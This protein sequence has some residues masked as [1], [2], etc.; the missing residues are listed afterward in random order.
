MVKSIKSKFII[1]SLIFTL[2]FETS[3]GYVLHS[4]R[5][6][7]PHSGNVDFAIVGLDA[8]GLLFFIVPGVIAFAVDI[9]SNTIYLPKGEKN[10]SGIN[11]SDTKAVKFSGKATNEKIEKLVKENTGKDVKI[12]DHTLILW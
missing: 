10:F 12:D 8:I 7:K 1:L 9:S 4:E 3:C 5:R 2:L 6:N 11:S